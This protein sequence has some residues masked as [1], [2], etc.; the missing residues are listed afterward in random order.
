[1]LH[2]LDDLLKSLELIRGSFKSFEQKLFGAIFGPEEAV[3]RKRRALKDNSLIVDSFLVSIGHTLEKSAMIVSQLGAQ[4][5]QEVI[6]KLNESLNQCIAKPKMICSEP[7][8]EEYCNMKK[9][10]AEK[11]SETE[12]IYL[13]DKASIVNESSR[14]INAEDPNQ[15]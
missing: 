4:E 3:S 15:S 14:I 6:E 1:M 11:E 9:E 10:I 7:I 12:S 2:S 8:P 13:D 5:Q